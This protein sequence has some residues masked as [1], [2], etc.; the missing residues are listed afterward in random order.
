MDNKFV[1]FSDWESKRFQKVEEDGVEAP[2]K[3]EAPGNAA[4]HARLAEIIKVRRESVRS[5]DDIKTQILDI[6]TKLI[7]LDIE[8]NDLLKRKVDLQSAYEIASKT[9]LEGK[10]NVKEDAK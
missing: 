7:R 9:Q 10:T 6:E 8:K 4:L 3:T 2:A 1:R 5:K